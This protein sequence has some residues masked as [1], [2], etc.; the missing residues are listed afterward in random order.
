MSYREKGDDQ[1]DQNGYVTAQLYM[2][3]KSLSHK[4]ETLF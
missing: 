2:D 4:Q 3:A 1:I